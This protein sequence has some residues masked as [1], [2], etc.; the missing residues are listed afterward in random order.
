[1]R[2]RTFGLVDD[3]QAIEVHALRA[4]ASLAAARSPAPTS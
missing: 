3:E 2:C 4:L 1:V